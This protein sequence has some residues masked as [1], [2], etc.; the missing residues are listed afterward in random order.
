MGAENWQP[1]IQTPP[2]PSYT[3]GHATTSAAAAEVM[4]H[5]FGDNLSFIDTSSLE[6]GIEPRKIE[7]FRKAAEEAALSRLYGGIHYRFD[8][9]EGTRCGTKLGE[10]IV[11]RLQFKK[12]NYQAQN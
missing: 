3:S 2:F 1:Y 8:N 12:T 9:E 10:Y 4:T 7:S 6:F 5:W 11:N